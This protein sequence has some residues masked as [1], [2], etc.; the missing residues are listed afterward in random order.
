MQNMQINPGHAAKDWKTAR[1]QL[2][3][4]ENSEHADDQSENKRQKRKIGVALS[5]MAL[6]DMYLATE[7]EF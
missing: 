2:K 6:G 4:P 5:G 7:V 1:L 3:K